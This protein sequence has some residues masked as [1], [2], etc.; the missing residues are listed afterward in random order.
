MFPAQG[1]EW[2]RSEEV[3]WLAVRIR[4]ENLSNEFATIETA[5]R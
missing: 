3:W 5:V 4:W 1:Y 2:S